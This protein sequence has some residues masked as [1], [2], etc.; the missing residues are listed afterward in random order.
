MKV[1]TTVIFAAK[2]S[3]TPNFYFPQ[4]NKL[5]RSNFLFLKI[6]VGGIHPILSKFQ[7][8][9]V[10]G[11]LKQINQ[12]GT[13]CT[14]HGPQWLQIQIKC[15]SLT[16]DFV[17]RWHLEGSNLGTVKKNKNICVYMY[18]YIHMY[19]HGKD[20]KSQ[21]WECPG[22]SR[23]Y[24]LGDLW[25][26]KDKTPK[27]CFLPLQMLVQLIVL[28]KVSFLET[29]ALIKGNHGKILLYPM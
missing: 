24:F 2:I 29:V 26:R 1:F 8:A 14:Q 20:T 12:M 15:A 25:P 28:Q 13:R 22:S 7:R 21:Y 6:K 5:G 16:T 9:V 17:Q 4:E 23:L 3:W 19:M 10:P 27:N 11:S 18:I